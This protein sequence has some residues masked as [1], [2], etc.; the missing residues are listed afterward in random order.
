M[1]EVRLVVTEEGELDYHILKLILKKPKNRTTRVLSRATAQS[2]SFLTASLSGI[3]PSAIMVDRR[4][5]VSV[6]MT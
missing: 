6:F 2:S 4:C 3:M 5:S 1:G